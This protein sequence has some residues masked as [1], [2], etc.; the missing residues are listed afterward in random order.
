MIALAGDEIVVDPSSI[1]GSIGVVFAGFGF[2]RLLD[3]L[4]IDRR[5]HTAGQS[6]VILDPF[7]PEKPEDV[8]RLKTLQREVHETFI[9]LV[10]ARRPGLADDPDLFT[11]AFWSGERSVALGLADRVGDLDSVL[12]ERYGAD[13][14]LK[15][16]WQRH[17]HRPSPRPRSARSR[18]GCSGTA[19]V[20]EAFRTCRLARRPGRAVEGFPMLPVVV[21]GLVAVVAILGWRGVKTEQKRVSQ[22]LRQAQKPQPKAAPKPA[23]G[24]AP[25]TLERDPETGVYKLK[26]D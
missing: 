2:P 15:V 21:I 8:A 14:R 5:V 4:G 26:D 24:A 13:V 7:Q 10:K 11:G 16:A 6:K 19:T 1:V 25:Q 20:C 9:A 17:R 12:R 18:S 3:K 22:K 23:R